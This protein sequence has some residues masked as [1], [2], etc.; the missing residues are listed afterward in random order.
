MM[1]IKCSIIVPVYNTAPYLVQCIESLLNQTYRNIEIILV[2]DGS[3]DDSG[4]ICDQYA[5]QDERIVVIHKTNAGPS[6]T[7]K[8]GVHAASGEYVMIVDSDDWLDLETV[9]LCLTRVKED[10]TIQ[11]VLFSYVREYPNNSLEVHLFDDDKYFKNADAKQIHRRLFGLLGAELKKPEQADSVVS[12]CMKLYHKDLIQ[13]GE[14][15]DVQ[16]VGSAEDALFNMY[17]L[18][19]CQSMLYIDKCFY[20]YRKTGLTITST[21]RPRL[22]EQWNRLFDIMA[23]IIEEKKLDDDYSQALQNRIALSIIGIGMNELSKRERKFG[24]YVK[25]I[26]KYL[27]SERVHM[28]LKRLDV[29]VMPLKWK[30]FMLCSRYKMA[31]IVTILLKIMT[32][33]KSKR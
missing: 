18:C 6:H 2:D 7:R 8:T 12:C 5:L 10:E 15:F 26:R 33:L 21:Y 25:A 13:Q 11:C 4:N 29:S 9:E 22:V 19:G 30:A 3:T 28:A 17:A 32:K 27:K 24:G 16:E 23:T 20:H 14:Y 31:F 1:E